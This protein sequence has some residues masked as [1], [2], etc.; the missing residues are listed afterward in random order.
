VGAI[1]E[2][3][4]PLWRGRWAVA[5][6]GMTW[7]WRGEG[8]AGL[9]EILTWIGEGR[10]VTENKLVNYGETNRIGHLVGK[11]GENG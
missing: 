2:T 8:G 11:W 5:G 6:V 9:R 1:G 7:G 10:H 3:R 4:A